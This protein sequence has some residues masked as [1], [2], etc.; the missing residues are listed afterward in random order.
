MNYKIAD[1]T[2]SLPVIE[3]ELA[4]ICICE[5]NDYMRQGIAKEFSA[6]LPSGFELELN[7]KGGGRG[8]KVTDTRS[9]SNGL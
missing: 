7:D 3:E 2:T 5:R 1:L 4:E 6:S 9:F 8:V